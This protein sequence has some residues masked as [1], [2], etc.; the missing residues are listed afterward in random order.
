MTYKYLLN[1]RIDRNVLSVLI[2]NDQC[3]QPFKAAIFNAEIET[4]INRTA[5]K[6]ETKSSERYRKAFRKN[7]DSCKFIGGEEIFQITPA[8]FGCRSNKGTFSKA[9]FVQ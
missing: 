9:Q 5:E 7:I 8:Y 4:G 6:E 1:E 2:G 3:C